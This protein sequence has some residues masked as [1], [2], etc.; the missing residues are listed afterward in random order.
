MRSVQPSF[1]NFSGQACGSQW[2]HSQSCSQSLSTS[3]LMHD[4]FTISS[5]GYSQ[6]LWTNKVKFTSLKKAFPQFPQA[7]LL[8]RITFYKIIAVVKTLFKRRSSTIIGWQEGV[9]R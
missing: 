5:H 2:G 3:R 1:H 9:L 6:K 8:L 4:L 7:L